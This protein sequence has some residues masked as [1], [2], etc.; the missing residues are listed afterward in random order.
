MRTP[1]GHAHT[2][3]AVAVYGWKWAISTSYD[4]T[5]K[6]WYLESGAELRT[7]SGHAL[8]VN[9]VAVYEDGKRAISASWDHTLKLWDLETGKAIATFTADGPIKAFDANYDKG[10]IVAG[11]ELGR[12]HI[13]SLVEPGIQ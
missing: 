8:T 5:L 13:L 6:E 9:A 4:K 11:D 1:R 3:T 10:I 12:V 7:L 2:V